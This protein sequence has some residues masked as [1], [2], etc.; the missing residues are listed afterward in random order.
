MMSEPVKTLADLHICADV[1]GLIDEIVMWLDLK[2]KDWVLI[3]F[4][5]IDH[6][7]VNGLWGLV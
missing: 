5:N 3:H 4:H 2:D 1:S 7:E 6:G